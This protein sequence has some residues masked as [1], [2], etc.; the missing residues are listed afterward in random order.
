MVGLLKDEEAI[1]IADQD[2][3]SGRH[4]DGDQTVEPGCIDGMGPA[5]EPSPV[6]EAPS[7]FGFTRRRKAGLVLGIVA[8]VGAV[9]F[10]AF[11]LFLR[12]QEP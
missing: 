4:D 12:G 1:R 11:T 8:L 9:V 2:P 3:T 7:G 6:E 5:G 10:A